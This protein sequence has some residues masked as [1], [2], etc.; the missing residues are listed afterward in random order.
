MS[1]PVSALVDAYHVTNVRPHVYA[2]VAQLGGTV[3]AQAALVRP[4]ARVDPHVLQQ[5][6]VG[7][8]LVRALGTFERSLARVRP[9][10]DL[11]MGFL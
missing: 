11:E 8:G 6:G 1:D 7:G 4:G 3:V 9:H 2:Q 5:P 10:V